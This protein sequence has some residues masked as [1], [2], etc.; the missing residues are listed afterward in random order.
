LEARL[1]VAASLAPAVQLTFNLGLPLATIQP[2]APQIH[3]FGDDVA[4]SRLQ[5]PQRA[6]QGDEVPVVATWLALNPPQRDYEAL[7]S[8]RD[9]SGTA[10][11][12]ATQPLAPG[13]PASTW[14]AGALVEGRAAL[15][16]PGTLP[17][18]TYQLTLGLAGSD[19]AALDGM[20]DAGRIELTARAHSFTVPEMAVQR[21]DT[22]G[23]QIRLL[24]YDLEREGQRLHLR[25]YWTA[26]TAVNG[27]Y[28]V[29]VHL[30]DPASERI[31]A[32]SDSRPRG[33]T[34]P[35]WQWLPGE[36]VSDEV[37]LS[38]ADVPP[39]RYRLGLGVYDAA[40]M[41]RLPALDPSGLP[42]PADRLMLTGE[43]QIP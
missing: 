11:Y 31:V 21:G 17:A 34:Y 13:S 12:T 4:L 33:G 20:V 7:W 39:G 37:A 3:R 32:Q 22:F 8:L 28:T 36:V 42:H 43:V 30:F 35:A 10:V 25:L 24:G 9:G 1:Y 19:G 18:G 16:L 40:T 29:F 23:G 14:P 27:D 15:R 2:D 41:K 6:G 38:L 5:V 26:P